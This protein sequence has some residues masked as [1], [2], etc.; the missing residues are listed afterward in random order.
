MS[1]VQRL[2]NNTTANTHRATA[3]RLPKTPIITVA[4]EVLGGLLGGGPVKKIDSF[5][6]RKNGRQ[7]FSQHGWKTNWMAMLHFLPRTLKPVLH[8][9]RLLQ[10]AQILTSD[11]S[12]LR[13][14]LTKQRL[15]S[16]ITSLSLAGKKPSFAAMLQNL[17]LLLP[18]ISYL[19]GV[20]STEKVVLA[21]FWMSSNSQDLIMV[22][23]FL[24][25]QR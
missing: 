20:P 15:T 19:Y 14:S 7:P 12:K 8:Q 17:L 10:V 1:S 4:V 3:R 22:I 16:R 25:K 2:R 11:W 21:G 24:M 18:V 9:I 13:V 5:K 6:L 23:E